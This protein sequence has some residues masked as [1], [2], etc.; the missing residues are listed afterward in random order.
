[1]AAP[2]M[3]AYFGAAGIAMMSALFGVGIARL[4]W[5]DDLKHAQRIDEIRSR[6][7][8]ALRNTITSLERQ[9]ELKK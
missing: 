6:T 8:V 4:I 3:L 5:D 1:M 9:L 7:E 2:L